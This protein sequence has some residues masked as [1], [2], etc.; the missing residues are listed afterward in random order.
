MPPKAILFGAIGTLTETSDIQREAFNAAF[1][2]AG[3]DWHWDHHGYIDMLQMP[4]GKARIARFAEERD[5]DVDVDALHAAKVRHFEELVRTK[6]IVP[7][8]GVRE[9]INWAQERDIALGFA[10]TTSPETVS[11]ILNGLMPGIKRSDF[12]FVGD[13]TQVSRGKPAPEIYQAALLAL[14]VSARDAIAIEDTPESA[15]AALAAGLRTLG[16]AGEAAHDR[17]FPDGVEIVSALHPE[18]FD[19]P[20]DEAAE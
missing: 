13:A 5:E 12:G 8:P 4:G 18:F 16:F 20:R 3:L 10:T 15:E 2:E 1:A 19:D 9:I 11:L 14:G 6:H 7:R 17:T